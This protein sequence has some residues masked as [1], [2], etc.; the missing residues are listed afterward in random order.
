[1]QALTD[2]MHE[3]QRLGQEYHGRISALIEELLILN[4]S[5]LAHIASGPDPCSNPGPGSDTPHV[6]ALS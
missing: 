5:P 1:M 2:A 4:P 3:K 6:L